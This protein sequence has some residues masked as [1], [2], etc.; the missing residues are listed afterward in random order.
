MKRRLQVLCAKDNSQIGEV[1]VCILEDAGHTAIHATDG[2]VAWEML[3]ANLMTFDVLVTDHQMPGFTGLELV[4]RLREKV[5][6]G[7]IYV[8]SSRVQPADE[9]AYRQQ[10]V[11]GI[12]SKNLGI[13]EFLRAVEIIGRKNYTYF[14]QVCA[15]LPRA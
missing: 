13:E 12:F 1:M 3:N 6:N 10:R 11:D 5:F 15:L 2:V 7:R 4:Q 14:G 8:Y 9:E